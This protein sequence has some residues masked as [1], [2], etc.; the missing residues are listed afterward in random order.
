MRQNPR[1]LLW[2]VLLQACATLLLLESSL[3]L[4][5]RL[6]RDLNAL[7]Y[8]PSLRTEYDDIRSIE[9]LLRGTP[10]GFVPFTQWKGFILNSRS[11]RTKEYPVA[12]SPGAYR[13]A[14]IGDSFTVGAGEYGK[15]WPAVLERDLAALLRR[16]VEVFAL[17][18][19]GVGPQFELKLWE[20]E[21]DLLRPDLVVVAFFVGNDFTDDEEYGLH[22][23]GETRLVRTSYTARLARNLYRVWTEPRRGEGASPP[24]GTSNRSG[25]FEVPAGDMERLT[26][27][28]ERHLQ[29][30]AYRLQICLREHRAEFLRLSANVARVLRRF[31]AEV[32]A[33][34]A[35]FAIMIVPDEFQVDEG[36]RREVLALLDLPSSE[37][38][39][40]FPQERLK[41]LL[42]EAGIRHLDLLPAFRDAGRSERLYY[43]RNTH[44]NDAGNALAARLLADDVHGFVAARGEAP[45]R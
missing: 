38:D 25:G 32:R 20:L 16:P 15:T 5:G 44:W 35:D 37:V 40:D 24:P 23:S 33:A 11:L 1:R 2:L 30:E 18:V 29:I 41:Q 22:P 21:R 27:S 36:L 6:S 45:L 7:L 39:L 3:R 43:E 13:I 26:F 4:F 8:V 9:E 17:G 19:P 14:A 10:L 42:D 12:R 31:Q 34:G 28:A